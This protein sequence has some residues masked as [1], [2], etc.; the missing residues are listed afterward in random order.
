MSASPRSSL[1]RAG[2]MIGGRYRLQA[3]IGA[4]A[5]GEVWRAEHATLGTTVAVKLVDTANRE[6]AQETL[7]R[8]EVEARA[9][10]QLKSPHVVHI[11]DYGADGR[12]AFIAM[13]FLEG[14]NLEKRLERR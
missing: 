5:M 4:G 11:L 12:V 7:A 9:A 14:E 1:W 2:A 10:A 3:P 13:E 8:F 6:D